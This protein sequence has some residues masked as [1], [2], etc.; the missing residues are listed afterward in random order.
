MRPSDFIN[1]I[2]PAAIEDMLESGVLASV[3]VAQ[4]AIESAWG[5]SAPHNN[6][7]G[8]KGAGSV[9]TTKEYINGEWITI[10]DSFRIYGD[11]SGSIKGHSEFLT[12]NGRYASAGFF[13]Y[14]AERDYAGA[15]H[16]LQNAGYATDPG[17]ADLI[18]SVIERNQLFYLDMEADA[19]LNE[20]KGQIEQLQARVT[21]LESQLADQDAPDYFT[22]EFGTDALD[23]VVDTPKGPYLF[24]RLVT[25]AYR[26]AKKSA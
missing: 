15:A 3:T 21:S 22:T 5:H 24:W 14:C 17:Y 6:L 19:V 23:G 2:G 10:E 16:A 12:V 18:I 13:G 11:W 4:A 1:E 7:F 9:Q 25:V 20:L 8:I 26:L